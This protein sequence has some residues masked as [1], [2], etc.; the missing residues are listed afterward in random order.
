MI[1]MENKQI[2]DTFA[3]QMEAF[4]KQKT[5]HFPRGHAGGHNHESSQAI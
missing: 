1:K 5:S 4:M 3:A 2:M